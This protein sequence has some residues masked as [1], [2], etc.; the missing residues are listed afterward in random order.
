M[1]SVSYLSSFS[2]SYVFNV[3]NN[4]LLMITRETG[5]ESSI[6]LLIVCFNADDQKGGRRAADQAVIECTHGME[7]HPS[8]PGVCISHSLP[9][10]GVR[11]EASGKRPDHKGGALLVRSDCCSC[12]HSLPSV[13]QHSPPLLPLYTPGTQTAHLQTLQL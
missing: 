8:N 11:T 12:L 2:P 5:Q 10:T 9:S 3:L 7:E 4:L 1:L 13:P 6:L